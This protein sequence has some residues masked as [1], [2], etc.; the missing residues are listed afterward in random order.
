VLLEHD[1]LWRLDLVR[2]ALFVRVF[3]GAAEDHL[4][5]SVLAITRCRRSCPAAGQRRSSR[6]G[7][8]HAAS[9]HGADEV[10]SSSHGQRYERSFGSNDTGRA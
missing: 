5:V 2:V 9:H 3:V 10:P 8:V 7:N 1:D 4:T 6:A